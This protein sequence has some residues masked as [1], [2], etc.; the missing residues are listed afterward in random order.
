[1]K[2]PSTNRLTPEEIKKI[3]DRLELFHMHID[4]K[5]EAILKGK[6]YSAQTAHDMN[7]TTLIIECIP[8]LTDWTDKKQ[9]KQREV[10]AHNMACEAV[11]IV[12]DLLMS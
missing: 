12:R 5:L 2:K 11:W 3:K 9:E 7:V 4:G 1:M 8:S 6:P 10:T